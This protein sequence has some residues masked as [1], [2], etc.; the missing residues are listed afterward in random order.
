MVPGANGSDLYTVEV[1]TKHLQ[2]FIT[3]SA[4]GG[5][6][7]VLP[8]SLPVG[9][10]VLISGILQDTFARSG[11]AEQP[12]ARAPQTPSSI[13]FNPRFDVEGYST[14][15]GVVESEFD[16]TSPTNIIAGTI[17]GSHGMTATKTAN[18][19]RTSTK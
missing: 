14:G 15:L 9:T 17:M 18:R 19:D 6:C 4:V 12:A 13:P 3:S 11:P 7:A 5:K 16:P 2:R 10:K 8:L 1:S